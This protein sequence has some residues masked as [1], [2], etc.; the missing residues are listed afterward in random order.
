M[1]DRLE[2]DEKARIDAQVK[3]LGPE[4]LARAERLLEDA[5]AEHDKPIPNEVISTF[6]V[7]DVKTITWINVQSVQEPGKGRNQPAPKKENPLSKH[8]GADGEP[9]PFFVQYDHVQVSDSVGSNPPTLNNFLQSDF[10]TVAALF[11]LT[12]LPNKLRPCVPRN[13][14]AS[15]TNY[16]HR[17]LSA[18][19]GAFFSLPVRR[20]S[21]ES[22][23]HE[24]VVNK[25]DDETVAYGVELGLGS[26]FEETMQVSIKVETAQYETAIAWLRDLLYGSEFNKERRVIL[27]A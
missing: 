12:N 11:S 16:A 20:L 15:S 10:V 9:L 21:G 24:E 26:T 3:K 5:K 25:L 2:K 23:T 14:K 4:G 17:Y 7:P 8:I 6:N 13:G 22:L 18:Y 19:L 27:F 1:A